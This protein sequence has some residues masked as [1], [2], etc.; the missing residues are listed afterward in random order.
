MSTHRTT[1]RDFLIGSAAVTLGFSGLG[2]FVARAGIVAASEESS[3]FGWGPLRPD[4]AGILD[5]PLGFEYQVI[6]RHGERMSDGLLVPPLHDGMA[7]FRGKSGKTIL[8]R[9]HEVG[10]GAEGEIADFNRRTLGHRRRFASDRCYDVTDDGPC[11]GGTTTLVYDT[12]RRTLESH[13][14]SLAGTLRNCAGG[15]TPRGTWI[16]CE[17]TTERAGDGCGKDHGYAF[18]VP[19]ASSGLAASIPLRAMGRFR[20]EAVAVDPRT[21]I[22]YQTEDVDDGIL[23]RFL[24]DAHDAWL[25]GGRLQALAVRERPSLDTRNAADSRT[26]ERGEWLETEWIDLDEPEAPENDLRLRGFDAGGARFARAEGIWYG[27]GELYFACTTGGPLRA[28]QIWRY[29]P[30]RF[31]G[32]AD[33][34]SEPGRLQLF[35]EP[36]DT[37]ILE[38]CDN[39]TIAPW[40]DLIVSEDGRGRDRIV[41]VRPDGTTYVMARGAT[42]S[43]LAGPTFS[44]DGTT[45]FFNAQ[46]EGLTFAVTGPWRA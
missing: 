20:R 25:R 18:E 21:G 22:V 14:L 4:E 23:T 46:A 36:N 43:E 40:G 15:P 44:P 31:E 11:L 35:L 29:V 7:A 32:G 38:N 45:L 2:R 37:R 13:H 27:D 34:A 28:G 5:L 19:A 39:V 24:P 1:R 30:S 33:E 17:E 8:V 6:S 9:N 3:A 10:L 12:V 42:N 16:T 26:V 41:G